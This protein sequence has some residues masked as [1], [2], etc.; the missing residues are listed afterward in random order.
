MSKFKLSTRC[1]FLLTGSA[2]LL[3]GCGGGTAGDE[4]EA[5]KLA[6]SVE[7]EFSSE[8]VFIYNDSVERKIDE[9]INTLLSISI[10]K[11]DVAGIPF[12]HKACGIYSSSADPGGTT[13]YPPS[14]MAFLVRPSDIE[15]VISIGGELRQANG[16]LI[17]S[18]ERCSLR[19]RAL[20][21]SSRIV[22]F[23]SGK[24]PQLF[25]GQPDS[26]QTYEDYEYSFFFD[27]GIYL[28]LKGGR[29]YIHNGREWNFSDIGAASDYIPGLSV[30]QG[31]VAMQSRSAR[32]E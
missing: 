32:S 5:H 4:P 25:P 28:G 23:A 1:G 12:I 21:D 3:I 22:W 20:S 18:E 2:V 15:K 26:I 9:S 29:V 11:L 24:Y 7:G 30:N 14:A 31:S 10:Q 16:L 27:T 19:R 17:T 8:I 6:S 13:D